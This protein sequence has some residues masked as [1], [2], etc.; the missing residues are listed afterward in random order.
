MDLIINKV[1]HDFSEDFKNFLDNKI[2]DRYA[3]P[4]KEI[5]MKV[6]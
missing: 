5:I 1:F 3:K 4:V 6:H 2:F